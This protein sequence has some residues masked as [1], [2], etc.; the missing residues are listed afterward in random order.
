MSN[1]KRD[2][3]AV[4]LEELMPDATEEERRMAR[5]RLD[6]YIR[7]LMRISERLEREKRPQNP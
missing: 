7:I 4:W 3:I 2:E 6:D 5:E 1:E